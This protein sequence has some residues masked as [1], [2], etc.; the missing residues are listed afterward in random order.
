MTDPGPRRAGLPRGEALIGDRPHGAAARAIER[1]WRTA[2]HP[3]LARLYDGLRAEVTR[4]WRGY[5]VAAARRTKPDRGGKPRDRRRGGAEGAAMGR[6]APASGLAIAAA[7]PPGPT[8]RLCRLMARL[9][10]SE[11]GN[12][13]RARDWLD[14]AVAAPPDPRY[15]CTHCGARSGRPGTRCAPPAAGFDTLAWRFGAAPAADIPPSRRAL[16]APNRLARAATI[17]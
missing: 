12:S 4:R 16:P 5:A 2:P 11:H 1:A 9:E 7:P 10:E 15:V 13:G 8:R 17:G 6:G 14:R 3:E